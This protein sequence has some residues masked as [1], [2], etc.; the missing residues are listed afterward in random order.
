M[1]PRARM[2]DLKKRNT[3]L[4]AGIQ[5]AN[6]PTGI[7]VTKLTAIASDLNSSTISLYVSLYSKCFRDWDLPRYHRPTYCQVLRSLPLKAQPPCP[8][9]RN[10]TP[11]YLTNVFRNYKHKRPKHTNLRNEKFYLCLLLI[12]LKEKRIRSRE[13]FYGSTYII[14]TPLFSL[15][16]NK[17][18]R[19]RPP[20]CRGFMITLRHTTL[21]RTPLNEW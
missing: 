17:P 12:L 2:D 18:T 1:G 13:C 8:T 10:Y 11:V 6:L 4:S 14:N 5:P 20:P 3:F 21:G 15:W 7:V 16:R 9:N 19:L